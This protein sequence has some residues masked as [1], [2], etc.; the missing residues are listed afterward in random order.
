M[1]TGKKTV[2]AR[3]RLLLSTIDLMRRKGVAGAGVAEILEHGA[4]SRR[5]IY[6]HY[7]DGKS[8]L[9]AE[10]TRLAGAYIEAQMIA[11]TSG[12]TPRDALAAFI[13]DWKKVVSDSDF[14]AGCPVAAAAM[15]RST[16]PA[17]AD[18]AGAEFTR[19]RGTLTTSMVEHGIR[20]ET[21]GSLATT[22]LAAVE[23]AVMMCVAQRSVSA[24][25]DVETHLTVLLDHHLTSADTPP[26]G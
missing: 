9:V 5:S 24:L 1:A 25:D 11:A 12:A 22:V 7:P 6:L 23:G 13:A 21:A 3:D 15:S 8:G 10:A 16:T 26:R 20:E 2:G 19:W 4:V 14:D 18:L 17:V